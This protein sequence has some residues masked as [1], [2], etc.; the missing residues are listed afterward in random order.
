MENIDDAVLVP[1]RCVSELQGR[2]NTFVVNAEN[3]IEVRQI[4]IL[5]KY[6]DY[7]I[8]GSGLQGG[9]KIVYEGLQKVGSGMTVTPNIVK[10][11]SQFTEDQ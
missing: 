1:Q 11:E 6:K 5:S 4:E 3:K 9:D 7:Y 10:F 8:V 2:Y